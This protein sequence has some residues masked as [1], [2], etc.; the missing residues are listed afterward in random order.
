MKGSFRFSISSTIFAAC[1]LVLCSISPKSAYALSDEGYKALHIFSKVLHYVE[2]N[3]V[4]EV[5]DED[6]IQGAIRGMMD[7][8]DPHSVYMS[9]EI[10]RELKVDTKGRFDGIGIEVAVRGGALVVVSPI[11]GSPADEAGIQ[12]GDQIIKIN[13]KS[14]AGMDLIE[15]VT[16]MRGK[17][18][19]KVVL[20]LRREGAKK[21]LDIAVV[22][23]IINIPSVKW[24]LYD[25]KYGYANITNF[26]QGTARSLEKAIKDL[27]GQVGKN[28]HIEG[29]ILDLRKNPGGL[30]EQAVAV[31]DLFLKTGT[32]VST[33]SRGK[34]I[35]RS[36]AHEK[37][38]LPDYPIIV[39]VDGGSA[40]A[41]EIVAGALQDNRRAVIMGTKSFGK[42]SVQTVIDLDD[43]SGLKLTIARY[44]TPNGR[45]IQDRGIEPDVVVPAK[46]SAPKKEAAAEGAEKEAEK[47][48]VAEEPEYKGD[49]QLDRAID[50]IKNWPGDTKKDAQS[51]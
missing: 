2:E 9:P 20:T 21:P 33:V 29:L 38:T 40:S 50:Y 45:I 3:Y 24:A 5:N 25:G 47:E 7:A 18:G 30:L 42:G 51:S 41:S 6:L 37:D 48:P 4:D 15:A 28:A 1:L 39:L 16:N 11:K 8:L 34:E 36:E 44:L 49:Y 23:R 27:D 14:T 22:R 12:T 19:S 17:R 31:S 32:I 10:Y 13:G 35:D 46:P 43:G 26:Q